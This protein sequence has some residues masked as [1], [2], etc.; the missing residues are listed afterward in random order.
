[1]GG[2]G[3]RAPNGG[4]GEA[5]TPP[6]AGGEPNAAGGRP[7]DA[8]AAGTIDA[9]GPVPTGVPWPP[10]IAPPEADTATSEDVFDL[11]SQCVADANC[12]PV[13]GAWVDGDARYD[14]APL[15]CVLEALSRSEVGYL[16]HTTEDPD[17]LV[18]TVL[19]LHPVRLV[20]MVT[21]FQSTDAE[22]PEYSLHELC[23][24]APA[25]YFD[26]CLDALPEQGT[27]PADLAAC[28]DPGSWFSGCSEANVPITPCSP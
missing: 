1:M 19:L 12:P 25:E 2:T 14:A 15:R 28:A 9:G 13:I 26:A 7:V 4:E 24:L 22:E 27:V 6:N 17:A 16:A 23:A 3:G 21:R 11:Y 10:E 18:E 5:G 8:P 20:D